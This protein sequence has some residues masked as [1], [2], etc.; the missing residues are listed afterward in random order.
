MKD[1]LFVSFYTKDIYYLNAAERLRNNLQD[2][3]VR[4]VVEEYHSSEQEDWADVTRHKIR[5]L[6]QMRK[7]FPN[8]KLVWVDVDSILLK[9][10]DFILNTSADFMAFSRGYSNPEKL[11]YRN[12]NRFWEPSFMVF[13]A[14]TNSDLLLQTAANIEK[15][16][17]IKATD[18]YFIESAWREVGHKL[19]YQIIPR[20]CRLWENNNHEQEDENSF[21]I[22]G[23]SGN[24]PNFRQIVAQHQSIEKLPSVQTAIN[25]FKSLLLNFEKYLPSGLRKGLRKGF[26]KFSPGKKKL[27]QILEAAQLGNKELFSEL[28]QGTKTLNALNPNELAIADSFFEY[29]VGNSSEKFN[30]MWWHKPFPGNYGDWL[31]PYLL[32]RYLQQSINFIDPNFPRGQRHLVAIGS[33]GR[34]IDRNSIVVG[35]GI[36]NSGTWL[37]PNANYISL[38]GP[39]TAKHLSL[40]G[41]PKIE[42]FGDLGAAISLIFPNEQTTDNGK[43]LLVR[44]FMHRKIPVVLPDNIEEIDVWASSPGQIEQ[45]I[46]ILLGY[47]GVLTSAMHVYITCQS[48]GIPAR[49]ITFDDPFRQVHGD[50]I[51]YRDYS[52]GVGLTAWEPLTVGSNFNKLDLDCILKLEQVPRDKQLE[53]LSYVDEAMTLYSEQS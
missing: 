7:K 12:H 45:F 27:N 41:G 51:K 50:G 34:Y 10:P 31:S 29:A 43:Y 49:L 46:K 2:L 30:L 26:I 6:Y 9:I 14:T 24:V 21:F 36:S 5:F 53:I 20:T 32:S 52:E 48:Y 25:N 3:G 23:A 17:Y 37:D 8:S 11:G 22:F 47:K 4:Y 35:T 28:R 44:H 33:I 40:S 1:T 38:R 39:I 13:G 16:T 18:D 42:K 15:N 19:T